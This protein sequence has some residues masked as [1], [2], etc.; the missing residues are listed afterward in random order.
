MSAY[1]DIFTDDRLL[2]LFPADRTD[3][4]FE[5]L[6]GDAEEGSY[7]IALGYAGNTGSTLNFEIRLTQRPGKCLACNLT[8]GLPQVFSRHPIINVNGLVDAVA[9]EVGSGS[10]TWRLGNTQELSRELHVIPLE[11]V[12]G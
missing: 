3:A 1:G 9:K 12:L 8:Y 6:F 4:F 7:D 11:I 10:A 5:A 2:T